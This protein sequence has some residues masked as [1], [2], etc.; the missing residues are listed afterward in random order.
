MYLSF[1]PYCVFC[2]VRIL[3]EADIGMFILK[4][5]HYGIIVF[6]CD[7]GTFLMS[8]LWPIGVIIYGARPPNPLLTL[9]KSGSIYGH[10]LHLELRQQCAVTAGGPMNQTLLTTWRV[11]D[12]RWIPSAGERPLCEGKC[13]PAV[14]IKDGIIGIS[15]QVEMK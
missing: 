10:H 1:E 7:G 3:I 4:E 8:D 6:W 12:T 14:E 2:C 15:Q 11:T 5:G 9:R 13:R